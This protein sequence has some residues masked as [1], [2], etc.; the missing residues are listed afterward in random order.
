M[1]I[2]LG[3]VNKIKIQ[4][5]VLYDIVTA[6]LLVKS[7]LGYQIV[8]ELERTLEVHVLLC[9]QCKTHTCVFEMQSQC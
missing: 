6:K 2:I 1:S 3:K 7:S 4:E 5:S 8:E 9:L